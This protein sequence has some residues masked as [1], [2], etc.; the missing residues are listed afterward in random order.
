M[1][2]TESDH[3]VRI[4]FAIESGSKAWGFVSLEWIQSPSTYFNDSKFRIIVST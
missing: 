3:N 4:L 2:K 1:R